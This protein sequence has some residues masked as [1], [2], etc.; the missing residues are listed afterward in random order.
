MWINNVLKILIQWIS[1]FFFTLC[2]FFA[3]CLVVD[4]FIIVVSSRY[5]VVTFFF[6]FFFLVVAREK[7]HSSFIFPPSSHRS[8]RLQ[9]RRSS[10]YFTSFDEP[11]SYS[12]PKRHL[13][14]LRMRT[15]F[16]V[17]KIVY[18][19]RWIRLSHRYYVF[20]RTFTD[21]YK[22][23]KNLVRWWYIHNIPRTG[24]A[25]STWSFKLDA[26]RENLTV[27]QL[28]SFK[29]PWPANKF[30]KWEE[31]KCGRKSGEKTLLKICA[32]RAA[33]NV[34][35]ESFCVKINR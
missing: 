31:Q 35:D 25:P 26:L 9:T 33:K 28:L 30:Y 24:V 1:F 27:C 34:D 11:Y 20:H 23:K 4:V 3:V 32:E 19:S 14:T 5:F 12:Q 22:G 13:W 10:S 18:F 21:T 6:S 17:W 16:N 8:L 7:F 15:R 2:Y 29:T